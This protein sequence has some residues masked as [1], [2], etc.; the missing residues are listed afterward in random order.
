MSKEIRNLLLIYVVPV[1]VLSLTMVFI[2]PAAFAQAI[3]GMLCGVG[4]IC[5]GMA[6][7]IEWFDNRA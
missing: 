6:F 7:L 2:A 3:L 4:L 5:V 1:L